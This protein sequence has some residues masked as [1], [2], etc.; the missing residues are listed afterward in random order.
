M[1]S[2]E[3]MEDFYER[4]LADEQ[5]KDVDIE[6]ANG[7]IR[8]HS[9]LLSAASDAIRGI[10]SH[11][12]QPPKDALRRLSWREHTVEVG[13]FFLQLL[14][15]GTVERF[16]GS[17]GHTDGTGAACGALPSGGH[18]ARTAEAGAVG[19]GKQASSRVA[20]G[21]ASGDGAV[22][23]HSV[24]CGAHS[25][26]TCGE[27][28]LH[29]LLGGLGIASVYLIPHL[30]QALTEALKRRL[31]DSTF[32]EIC[33]AAIRLDN[34]ALRLYCLE[35]ARRDPKEVRLEDLRDGMRVRASRR[36]TVEAA[37]VPQGD[38]GRV[39]LDREGDDDSDELEDGSDDV[40][41]E[42][43]TGY[44]NSAERVLDAVEIVRQ[45]GELTLRERYETKELSPEVL[46]ELA[47]VWGM[48]SPAKRRRCRRL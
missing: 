37:R 4:L 32:N 19:A 20:R 1:V 44:A 21:K 47:G 33:S 30:C 29:L 42:W 18:D 28:P 41:I 22:A 15:T 36:I 8:A 25:P 48:M 3:A 39:M 14:Y 26:S 2:V 45:P 13:R 5:T 6:M 9:V 16:N 35:Y 10:L 31:S 23:A 12:D 43:E 38:L 27:V 46:A 11:G 34:T 24:C 40:R 17:T 7:S